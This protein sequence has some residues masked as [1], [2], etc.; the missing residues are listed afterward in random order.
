M[1]FSLHFLIEAPHLSCPQPYVMTVRQSMSIFLWSASLY[2]RPKIKTLFK[3]FRSEGR[4][5]SPWSGCAA[6]ESLS[7]HLKY[8]T[9]KLFVWFYIVFNRIFVSDNLPKGADP[10]ERVGPFS[11]VWHNKGEGSRSDGIPIFG[12]GN[13]TREGRRCRHDRVYV[14]H[15]QSA[16]VP[17]PQISRKGLFTPYRP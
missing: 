1:T 9:E 8:G 16:V 2:L 14:D 10:C 3:P 5:H 13:A 4:C 17:R 11:F 15:S 7:Q 12:S 6:R